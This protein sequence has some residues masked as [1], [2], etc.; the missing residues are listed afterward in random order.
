MKLKYPHLKIFCV[1]VSNI[2]SL[3]RLRDEEAR[4]KLIE[5]YGEKVIRK[6]M[7]M[8]TLKYVVFIDILFGKEQFY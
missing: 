7:G 8:T 4:N 3:F 1:P 6:M 5:E 2:N